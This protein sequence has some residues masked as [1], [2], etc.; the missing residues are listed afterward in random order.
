MS[1]ATQHRTPFAKGRD[2][3]T[4][5]LQGRHRGVRRVASVVDTY[6]SSV[7]L[8]DQ[9]TLRDFGVLLAEVRQVFK[10]VL[11]RQRMND[12]TKPGRLL[13]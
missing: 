10:A 13:K 7:T 6:V 9:S 3:A 5:F 2:R 12:R 4:Q 1:A 8:S 11:S